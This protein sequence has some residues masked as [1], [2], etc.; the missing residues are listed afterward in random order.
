MQIDIEE[1][2]KNDSQVLQGGSE[3]DIELMIF[4]M[5]MALGAINAANT[6]Q[7]LRK[8]SHHKDLSGFDASRPSPISLCTRV[9]QLID[10]SSHILRP[11]VGLIQVFVLIA[12]YSSYGPTGSSQWQLA[13]FAMRMAVEL[14]LHCTSEASDVSHVAKDQRSRVFW[15]IYAIETSLAY[16]LGRPPSIGECHIASPLPIS[17]NETLT[18]LH[19][20][21]HRQLQS[22]IVAKVYGI[23]SSTQNM[24][25][26]EKKLLILDLQKELDEWQANIPADSRKD[27]SYPYSYW[28]RLYHGTSFVLHRQSPLCPHPS[29]Q[30]RE[31]CIRS[32]GKYIDG[33]IT[34]LRLSNIPL[35]WML[36]QG[37]LFAGLTMLI[38]ARTGLHQLLSHVE[39]SFLLVDLQSWVRNCSICLTIMNER[40]KEELLSKLISQYELLA[41]DTLK[42]VSSTIT[43]QTASRCT[44]S[45]VF[46]TSMDNGLGLDQGLGIDTSYDMSFG[47][48]YGYFD[49]FKDFMGQDLTQTFW[50]IFPDETNG[51][52]I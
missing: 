50:N 13:G 17:T 18:S 14:G 7:Q 43:S 40:L 48:E 36:V 19:Y 9:L 16:N 44:E 21:R 8:E 30:S 6:I 2:G 10:Y 3:K 32:A 46:G 34:I 42:L 35:S 51:D 52:T 23:N 39:V 1:I 41:N 24:Q 26:E 33:I 27:A 29:V 4:Y 25:I 15:S 31:R 11:S 38:T 22:R 20:V 49:I 45:S 37:V 5:V 28:N 12:I 47:E